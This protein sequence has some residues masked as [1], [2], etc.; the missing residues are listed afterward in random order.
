MPKG[1]YYTRTSMKN[2]QMHFAAALFSVDVI[3]I[4]VSSTQFSGKNFVTTSYFNNIF[5]AC[6]V[7]LGIILSCAHLPFKA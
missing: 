5:Q 3:S 6:C 4:Q 1:T 2:I 7:S